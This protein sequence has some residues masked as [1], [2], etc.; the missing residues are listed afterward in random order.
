MNFFQSNPDISQ[1]MT[2]FQIND[3]VASSGHSIFSTRATHSLGSRCESLKLDIVLGRTG[4]YRMANKNTTFKTKH[5]S[6]TQLSGRCLSGKY[7]TYRSSAC[8]YTPWNSTMV[9]CIRDLGG[10]LYWRKLDLKARLTRGGGP[11]YDRQGW[12]WCQGERLYI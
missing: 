5:S 12:Y 2:E 7:P 8:Q 9:T 11:D 3:A 4:V 1:R 6:F 10:G